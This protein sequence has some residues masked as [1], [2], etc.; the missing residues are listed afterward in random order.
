MDSGKQTWSFYDLNIKW[1]NKA[2]SVI[3]LMKL[4]LYH[5]VI[6]YPILMNNSFAIH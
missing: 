3:K 1:W 5:F 2:G 4:S 6:E